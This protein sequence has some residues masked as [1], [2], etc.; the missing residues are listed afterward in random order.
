MS[1]TIDNFIK[2]I[3]Y[4]PFDK[5]ITIC[6]SNPD[7]ISY[8]NDSKYNNQWKLL[9]DNTFSSIYEY[10]DKLKQI[11]N[12]LN[13]GDNVYNYLIYTQLVHLLD[14][15]TQLKIYY[16]QGDIKSFDDNKFTDLQRYFSLKIS[17]R[18]SVEDL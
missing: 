10:D 12:D 7:Y 16:R 18:N 1:K 6:Q 11:W 8:C 2:E 17:K 15:I 5:V 14:P 4:L 3:T 13:T 9:I